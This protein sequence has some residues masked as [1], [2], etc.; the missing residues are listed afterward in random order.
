M[1]SSVLI[2]QPYQCCTCVHSLPVSLIPKPSPKSGK[3]V[4]CSEWHFMSHGAG[5]YFVKNV[6]IALLNPELEFLTSQSIWTTTRPSLQ[7]LETAAKSVETAENR[8]RDNLS[9]WF[10]SK[11][12]RLHHTTII[13]SSAIWSGDHETIACIADHNL[14]RN[15]PSG[16]L[17]FPLWICISCGWVNALLA[18]VVH[19]N[20]ND[21]DIS[22]LLLCTS[23]SCK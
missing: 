23:L 21:L 6:I 16:Q 9:F 1:V 11:Y 10:V 4:W 14:L 22:F 19:M 17:H 18:L 7:K 8:L 2:A 3:R 12:N 13:S 5:P 20:H 15:L